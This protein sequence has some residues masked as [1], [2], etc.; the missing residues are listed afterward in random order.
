MVCE[1][2]TIDARIVRVRFDVHSHTASGQE[3]CDRIAIPALAGVGGMQKIIKRIE[4]AGFVIFLFAG[5]MVALG[6]AQ[7]ITIVWEIGLVILAICVLTVLVRA[8]RAVTKPRRPVT[9]K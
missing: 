9:K 6:L 7:K 3:L 5:F 4:K 8:T 1:C 2:V